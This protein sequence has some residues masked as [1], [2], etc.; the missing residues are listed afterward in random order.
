MEINQ[1]SHLT[2][3]GFT[4]LEW[5]KPTENKKGVATMSYILGM[6]EDHWKKKF[7]FPEF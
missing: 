7:L 2:I 3:L 6:V 4:Y 1:G 5:D